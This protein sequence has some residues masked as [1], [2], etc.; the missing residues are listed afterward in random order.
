MCVCIHVC[1]CVYLCMCECV[2][3][4]VTRACVCVHACACVCMHV[5]VHLRACVCGCWYKLHDMHT[6]YMYACRWEKLT[7]HAIVQQLHTHGHTTL[8]DTMK[9]SWWLRYTSYIRLAVCDPDTFG[10]NLHFHWEP[11]WSLIF[12]IL[13]VEKEPQ[14]SVS[15]SVCWRHCFVQVPSMQMG[16]QPLSNI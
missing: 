3:V 4:C 15:E 11:R 16:S 6:T 12:W 7:R 2:C 5:C 8:Q 1:P 14:I 13:G 10:G 9:G